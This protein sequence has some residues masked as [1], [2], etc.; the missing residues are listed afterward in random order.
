MSNIH[1]PSHRKLRALAL[2][3]LACAALGCSVLGV[4]PALASH[5]QVTFFEA[6]SDLIEVTPAVRAKT[7]VKLRSFG[8]KALRVELEWAKVA[9]RATS[10]KRPRF[11]A[12]NPASYNWG[13]YDPLLAEAQRLKWQVLLTV[14]SPVPK[15]ATAAH[16]DQLTRPNAAQFREFMTAVGRRYGGEVSLF[17]IWNE[18]NHPQFLRPQFNTRGT[19]ESPR[20]YRSLFQAGYEGL[21]SAGIASPKVLMGETAPVGYDRVSRSEIRR[22]GGRALLHDVAPLEFL[23]GALCLNA[24]YEKSGTCGML[25]AY[26]YAH[27]AYTTGAGPFYKPP[28]PDD[29]MIGVLSRLTN[30]I[31]KAERAHA[32]PA[33]TP[34]YLTEFG[35]QTRPSQLGVSQAKQ[36]EYDA[37]AEKIAWSNPRVAAFSQYLLRDDPRGGKAGAGVHGGTIGF[38]TGLETVSGAHKLLYSS[39]PVPLVVS[40]HG[41]G[42]SL[43]GLARPTE[44]ATTVTVLVQPRGS[45]SYRTLKVVQTDSAGYWTVSSSV[46]GS[47]WRVSWRSPGGAL[48]NGPPMG[49]N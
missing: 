34:I 24:K 19:P 33:H 14:T 22:E 16:R 25:P 35:I 45:K 26:G 4:A 2:A 41:H 15:W 27:H 12:T 20:I 18:A 6:P 46:Q 32:L 29:V 11:D 3:L 39:F 44:G 21:Q 38:E 49:A 28:E 13:P 7:L 40:R 1:A 9:P 36:A 43:W 31:G 8:V 17:A 23:R 10:A 30:A 47:R 37:I 48:Y 5:S 42:F